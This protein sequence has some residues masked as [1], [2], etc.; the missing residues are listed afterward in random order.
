M[1]ECRKGHRCGQELKDLWYCLWEVRMPWEQRG[2]RRGSHTGHPSLEGH[3]LGEQ[4]P[5]T[6][7]SEGQRNLASQV[8]TISGS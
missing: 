7:G 1:E 3:T 6:L 2:K 5:V 4:I 8:F